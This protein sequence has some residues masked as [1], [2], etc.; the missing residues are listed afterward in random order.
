[1]KKEDFILG[2]LTSFGIG[3]LFFWILR[4]SQIFLPF[5]VF[6][7]FV[8]LPLFTLFCLQIAFLV[9]QK[10]LFVWQLAKFA[11]VGGFFATIDLGI[12]NSLMAYFHIEKGTT[13]T[14]FVVVSFVI[15]TILKYLFDKFWV[16]EKK[17]REKL[18]QEFSLFFVVTLI[19]G[20]VHTAVADFIT[21]RTPILSFLPA[22][23]VANLGKILGIL[24]A[25]M[26]NFL[27]YKFLV[28]KK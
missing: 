27:G 20:L 21:N 1:M 2:I 18:G 16:F 22:L 8:F 6:L 4:R 17:E 11:L 10:F 12:L 5:D 7:F 3:G 28:F 24:T 19:S 15:A 13:Y 14:V 25:S 23:L 9:G 26:F